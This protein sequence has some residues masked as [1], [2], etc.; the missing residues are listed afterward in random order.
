MEW[1]DKHYPGIEKATANLQD[2]L[3]DAAMELA[4]AA[5]PIDQAN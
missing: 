5:Y 2:K 3:F 1:W 4:A